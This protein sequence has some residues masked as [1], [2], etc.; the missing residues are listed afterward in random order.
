[1]I[2]LTVLL[3]VFIFTDNSTGDIC[4]I[5]NFCPLGSPMPQPCPNATYMN[6][7]GGSQCYEC[8][9]GEWGML[10]VH[11]YSNITYVDTSLNEMTTQRIQPK[12]V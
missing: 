2:N 4:P 3:P 8:P 10:V 7:T 6:H 1:M 12:S 5:G 11:L 9:E